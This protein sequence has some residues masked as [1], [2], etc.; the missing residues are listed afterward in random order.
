MLEAT[1]AQTPGTAV[2]NLNWL[3]TKWH[4]FKNKMFVGGQSSQG[5]LTGG[6]GVSQTLL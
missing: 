4:V 1:F 5:S 3:S 2:Q 6:G